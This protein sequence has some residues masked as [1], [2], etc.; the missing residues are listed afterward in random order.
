MSKKILISLAIL[1]YMSVLHAQ[2]EVLIED[3]DKQIT[4]EQSNAKHLDDLVTTISIKTKETLKEGDR[5]LKSLRSN[6]DFIN[7][8]A[9]S[10]S[11]RD[12][13]VAKEYK[14]DVLAKQESAKRLF[15]EKKITNKQYLS[16]KAEQNSALSSLNNKIS[17][18][19]KEGE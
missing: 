19:C 10:Q 9:T 16:Y 13:V 14:K 17:K 15:E 8:V 1:G 18:I 6:L 2:N 7:R 3:I 12:C 4:I 5:A 11:F